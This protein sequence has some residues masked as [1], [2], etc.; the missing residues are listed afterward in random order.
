MS[1]SGG[2]HAD[3]S[4]GEFFLSSAPPVPHCRPPLPKSLL[5]PPS[6]LNRSSQTTQPPFTSI[7]LPPAHSGG[8]QDA[9]ADSDSVQARVCGASWHMNMS[10]AEEATSVPDW[11]LQ[12][13]QRG[14]HMMTASSRS[15][16]PYICML[17]LAPL[18]ILRSMVRLYLLPLQVEPGPG[19]AV[20]AATPAATEDGVPPAGTSSL[21]AC[22]SAR[23]SKALKSRAR[24]L[25]CSAAK[26]VGGC[27]GREELSG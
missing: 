24:S 25:V 14:F 19:A 9:A 20:A 27:I 1:Y 22:L 12:V 3:A 16:L 5:P 2:L 21:F 26:T 18:C 10:A 15:F 11:A 4:L 8:A 17:R 7:P 6:S 23:L 13:S